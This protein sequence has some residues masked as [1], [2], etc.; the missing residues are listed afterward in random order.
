MAQ[1][2]RPTSHFEEFASIGEEQPEETKSKLEDEQKALAHLS[3]LKGWKLIKE[4]VERINEELD[5]MV[6]LAMS[7]GASFEEIG[8]KTLV[9][10]LTKD[11]TRRI[12]AYADDATGSE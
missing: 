7:N 11:V 4:Y 2:L 12:I 5:D 1:A 6:R 8:K 9:K 3:K 10:E